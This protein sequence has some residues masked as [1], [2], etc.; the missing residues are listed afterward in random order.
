MNQVHTHK[1]NVNLEQ[2]QS[3]FMTLDSPHHAL[4]RDPTTRQHTTAGCSK[5]EV[6]HPLDRGIKYGSQTSDPA[7]GYDPSFEERSS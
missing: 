6:E 2:C 7:G 5:I 1:N 3:I 4:I